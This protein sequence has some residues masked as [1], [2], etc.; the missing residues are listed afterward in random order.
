MQSTMKA[1]RQVAAFCSNSRAPRSK[2]AWPA[3][4]AVWLRHVSQ[5]LLVG[6]RLLRS[7]PCRTLFWG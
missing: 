6:R 2:E 4:D 5:E 3:A 1:L 7:E